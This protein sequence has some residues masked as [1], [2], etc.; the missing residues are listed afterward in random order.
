MSRIVIRGGTVL[1]QSGQRRADVA[2]DDGLVME[3]RSSLDGD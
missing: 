2:I 3:T 1:D